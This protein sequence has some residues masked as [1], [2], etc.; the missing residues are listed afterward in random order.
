MR[1]RVINPLRKDNNF[2]KTFEEFSAFF[3]NERE[4]LIVFSFFGLLYDFS[5][6][7]HC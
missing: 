4:M 5:V 6:D 7:N 1:N 3:F 2:L